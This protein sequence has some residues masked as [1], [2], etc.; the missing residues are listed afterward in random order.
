[1]LCIR[2][3]KGALPKLRLGSNRDGA[4][5]SHH[6]GEAEVLL[7]SEVDH[8]PLQTQ[9]NHKSLS[10]YNWDSMLL[11]LYSKAALCAHLTTRSSTDC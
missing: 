8:W 2:S 5:L 9:T 1:M 3:Q 10:I 4:T 6:L 7:L 11:S